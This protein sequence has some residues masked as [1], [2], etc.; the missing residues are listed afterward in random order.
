M[1]ELFN[2]FLLFWV[3]V[4]QSLKFSFDIVLIFLLNSDFSQHLNLYLLNFRVLFNQFCQI[5]VQVW[6][7][8]LVFTSWTIK[9]FQDLLLA[10]QFWQWGIFFLNVNHFFSENLQILQKVWEALFFFVIFFEYFLDFGLLGKVFCFSL[11]EIFR[12]EFWF[13]IVLHIF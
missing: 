1:R 4:S 12:S 7:L 10:L 6:Y 8:I 13:G 2:F 11:F 9:V 5:F 3:D